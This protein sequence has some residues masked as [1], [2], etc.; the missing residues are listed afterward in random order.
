MYTLADLATISKPFN[1]RERKGQRK[2]EIKEKIWGG[3]VVEREVGVEGGE[4][5]CLSTLHL[6]SVTWHSFSLVPGRLPQFFYQ[7]M[8]HDC[9][10]RVSYP[11]STDSYSRT[12]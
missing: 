8:L 9:A 6:P 12:P 4:S 7:L 11:L 5:Y 3:G 10:C 2:R 1:Y